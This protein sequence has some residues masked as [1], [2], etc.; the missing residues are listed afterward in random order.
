MTELASRSRKVLVIP[1]DQDGH[2]TLEG[3][4][5]ER[6]TLRFGEVVRACQL[7]DSAERFRV[8]FNLLVKRLG[9]WL[10]DQHEVRSAFLTLRD[11]Q[12][13]FLV[14]T[15][16]SEYDADFEDALSDLDIELANDADLSDIGFGVLSLPNVPADSLE[17][18]MHPTTNFELTRG[19]NG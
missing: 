2:V 17:S 8:Q 10:K 1:Y 19:D 4:N 18:F 12:L 14:V 6:F 7:H 9:A 5:E 11:S 13:L 16:T 3:E 15:E